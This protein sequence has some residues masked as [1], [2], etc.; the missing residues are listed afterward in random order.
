MAWLADLPATLADLTRRWAL[1]VG[2]PFVDTE[3]TCSWVA[4][5][6]LPSGAD[7]VLKLAMPHMEG[8]QEIAGLRYWDGELTAR[9]LDADESRHALLLERCMPGT[10]LRTLPEPEQDVVLAEL[11]P[12]LWHP[13]AGRPRG[14]FAF[15]PLSA[16]IALW[17]GETRAAIDAWPDPALVRAG[18]D[19]LEELS[20]TS[21]EEVVLFTDL[22]ADNVLRAERAPW[23]AIDPK[24]FVGDPAYDATQHL[25]NC[26]DRMR[27]A[28]GATIDSFADRLGVSPVRVRGWMFARAAAGPRS[29]WVTSPWLEVARRIAP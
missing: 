8:E 13:R 23:L 17:A 9:L 7:A 24:P 20:A 3:G 10:R 21:P 15:R 25:F 27:A 11:L 1:V 14:D 2:P 5:V 4:P 18:L 12:R 29:D 6:R 26:L 22:H 16:V 19:V 28:P